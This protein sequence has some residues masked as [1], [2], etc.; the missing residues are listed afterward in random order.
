M[1]AHFLLP[2]MIGLAWLPIKPPRP[3]EAL[4]NARFGA[5]KG[6]ATG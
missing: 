2:A 6:G 4:L 5:R 1:H 3:A